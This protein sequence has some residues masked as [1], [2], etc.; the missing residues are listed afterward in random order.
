[1]QGNW[2]NS[3]WISPDLE[4]FRKTAQDLFDKQG[5][6]LI[7]VA[8]FVENGVRR[9][10]GISRAATWANRWW[11]SPDLTSFL[12]RAQ[13][14]F[15]KNGL[16]L[17]QA[18]SYVE[19]GKRKWI[20]IAQGGNW[21]SRLIVKPDL[22]SFAKEA[23]RLFDEKG[24]RL[25]YVT[26]YVEGGK[27][28]WFGISRFGD[29]ANRWWISPNFGSFRT[30]SQ[31]LFD[32]E[33]KRLIHVTTYVEGNQRRWVGIS[34]SGNW[35]NR[36]VF[37]SDVDSFNLEAQRLFDEEKLRLVHVEMLE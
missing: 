2:A 33:G 18:S 4:S 5:R 30:K 12:K 29:W 26:T 9:W 32:N 3:Y 16:R 7:R 6:R 23:Q 28:K 1:M 14:L 27:R 17:I 20:G 24:L 19:G 11:I 34:R 37:R 8:T 25:I 21:A 31:E 35:A 10:A 36:W 13:E 22:A 15:D